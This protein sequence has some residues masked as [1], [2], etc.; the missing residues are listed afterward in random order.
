MTDKSIGGSSNTPPKKVVVF[1]VGNILLSDEGVGVHIAH[2]LQKMELPLGV[3]I[4]EGG[5]DGFGL[6][7]IITETDR[8]VVIDSVKGGKKPGTIY[9]FDINPSTK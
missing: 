5:T 2:E 3:D 4:I 6:I 8:L 1:G 9:K 7:N